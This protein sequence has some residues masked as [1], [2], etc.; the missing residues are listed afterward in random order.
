L[1]KYAVVVTAE[2]NTPVKLERIQLQ[3]GKPLFSLKFE[4]VDEAVERLEKLQ[5]AWVMLTIVS[6]DFLSEQD[7][8]RLHSAHQGIVYIIPESRNILTSGGSA[9]QIDLSQDME[10]LFAQYFTHR[11]GQAPND[12]LISLFKEV[13]A[14]VGE[15]Q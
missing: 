4:S 15:E 5:D 11:L 7:R 14:I 1:D 10:T 12:D 13:Q 2:P 8:R 9:Q 6:D 3:S